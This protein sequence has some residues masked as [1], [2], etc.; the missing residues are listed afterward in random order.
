MSSLSHSHFGAILGACA[1]YQWQMWLFSVPFTDSD[2]LVDALAL[3][4]PWA[5]HPLAIEG[6][7]TPGIDTL[8]YN[9][10]YAFH[11]LDT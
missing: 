4:W 9:A 7:A 5:N 3:I 8:Y 10:V 1:F 11:Y 2:F 6:G